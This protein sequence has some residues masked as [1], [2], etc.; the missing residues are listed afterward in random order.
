MMKYDDYD[1]PVV[2]VFEVAVDLRRG[3]LDE[4][5]HSLEKG[6]SRRRWLLSH[7]GVEWVRRAHA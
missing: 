3:S 5:L 7:Q 4:E 2:E 6:G 1:S